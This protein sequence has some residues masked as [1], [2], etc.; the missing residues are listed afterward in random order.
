MRKYNIARELLIESIKGERRQAGLFSGS[1]LANKG[2]AGRESGGPRARFD[3][4]D[5]PHRRRR[6]DCAA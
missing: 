4:R 2:R 6:R 5:Y 3:V 1:I